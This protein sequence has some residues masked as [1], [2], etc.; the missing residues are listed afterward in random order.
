M[1]LFI[2]KIS[3]KR[4]RQQNVFNNSSDIECKEF[5][6]LYKECTVKPCFSSLLMLLLHHIILYVSERP[7]RKNVKTNHDN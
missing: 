2:M 5:K 3:N 6:N 1:H 4:E 7:F